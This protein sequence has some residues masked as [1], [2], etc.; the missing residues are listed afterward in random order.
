MHLRCLQCWWVFFIILQSTY[1]VCPCYLSDVK[2]CAS[3]ALSTLRIVTCIL[4]GR[5]PIC[6]Q[7][8]VWWDLCC[9]SYSSEVFTFIW[10]TQVL[11][12]LS[13]TL[14]WWR[15]VPLLPNTCNYFSPSVL[16]LSWFGSSII[17]VIFPLLMMNMAHFSISVFIPLS[18]LNILIFCISVFSSFSFLQKSVMSSD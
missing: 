15:H 6:S 9:I 1:I 16:I 18:R 7:F 2:T 8:I 11:I 17:S 12:F 14:V 13:S 3:P 10:S 4:Q 5:Q